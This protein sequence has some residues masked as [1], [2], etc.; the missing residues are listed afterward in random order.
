MCHYHFTSLL[1]A[2]CSYHYHKY[3]THYHEFNHLHSDGLIDQYWSLPRTFILRS[4][5]KLVHDPQYI[6]APQARAQ[7]QES[8]ISESGG[9]QAVSG[10]E[11]LVKIKTIRD[12]GIT[13]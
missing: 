10:S 3:Q 4:K 11:N 12:E 8:C 13:F 1:S 5:T 2:T 6:Y 9:A 7:T